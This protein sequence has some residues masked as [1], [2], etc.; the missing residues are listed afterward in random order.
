MFDFDGNT[1]GK[2]PELSEECN[3]ETSMQFIQDLK[4]E[5]LFHKAGEKI[6]ERVAIIAACGMECD[7]LQ[8]KEQFIEY[9]TLVIIGLDTF[10]ETNFTEDILE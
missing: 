3:K 9:L 1:I 7:D 6:C 4:A 10:I 2:E 5:F 8:K